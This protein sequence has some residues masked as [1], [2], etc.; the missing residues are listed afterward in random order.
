YAYELSGSPVPCRPFRQDQYQIEVAGRGGE[1]KGR[2]HDVS[3]RFEGG[4]F[5]ADPPQLRISPGDIVLWNAPDPGTPGFAV[6]GEG[7]QAF[8]SAA[9]SA[10]CVYSHAFGMAR[11]EEH[12]SELQS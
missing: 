5:V 6:P 12:T 10:E 11:S 7:D 1:G 2:Q 9:M 8:S 4:H 3:V